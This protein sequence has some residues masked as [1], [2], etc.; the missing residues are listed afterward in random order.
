[1]NEWVESRDNS[2]KVLFYKKEA[3]RFWKGV[4]ALAVAGGTIESSCLLPRDNT[5]IVE[6][7][8]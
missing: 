3:Q 4:V 2:T 1:M 5:S 6:L 7:S 8:E